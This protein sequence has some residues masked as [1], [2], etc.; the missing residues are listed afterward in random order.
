[1]S[2]GTDEQHALKDSADAIAEYLFTYGDDQVQ[3]M[4]YVDWA[5]EQRLTEMYEEAAKERALDW[6]AEEMGMRY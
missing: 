5:V 1:M 4:V 3:F 6:K 2:K